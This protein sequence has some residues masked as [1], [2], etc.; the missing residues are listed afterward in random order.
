MC[1]ISHL[2]C[3]YKGGPDRIGAT[4]WDLL[5]REVETEIPATYYQ[6]QCITLGKKQQSKKPDNMT[7]SRAPRCKAIWVAKTR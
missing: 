5:G 6:E 1:S 4:Q 3:P 7:I 2:P